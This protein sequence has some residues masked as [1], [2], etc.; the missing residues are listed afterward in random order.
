M[1]H[2]IKY[3]LGFNADL[4]TDKEANYLSSNLSKPPTHEIGLN[5]ISFTEVN[6]IDKDWATVVIKDCGVIPNCGKMASFEQIKKLCSKET[7]IDTPTKQKI[8]T[9]LEKHNLTHLFDK[10]EVILFSECY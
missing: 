2:Y 4:L 9:E 7:I 5:L 8:M 1:Q 10:I 6:E 3:G